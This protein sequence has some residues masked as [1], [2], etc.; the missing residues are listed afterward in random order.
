VA[1][2]KVDDNAPHHKKM[3]A[4]GDAACWLWVCGLAY[5]QRH[6]TDGVITPE[7]VPFL[8]CKGWKA[9]VP[10]LV[11]SG[12]W[13]V[14]GSGYRVH[15]FLH[16]NDSAEVRRQKIR[17]VN[18][19][20]TRF[21][22]AKKREGNAVGNS[23]PTPQP[24]PQPTPQPES[25]EHASPPTFEP[26]LPKGAPGSSLQW[27]RLHGTHVGGFC[28]W[29]CLPQEDFTRFASRLGSDSAAMA[30]A[31]AVRAS[32]VVATGKPWTFW[33]E[34]FDAAHGAAQ[35]AGGFSAAD[36]AAH[37]PGGAIDKKLGIK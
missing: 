29:M 28:D 37:M 20:V 3:L 15:D 9:A 32:G 2:L 23:T 4:A 17:D 10:K 18:E 22:E 14:D 24:L 5:C 35:K 19:R 12:L 34:Q 27:H 13:A 30:W 26:R 25:G 36:W 8:G 6:M 7:A 33:N 21:R 1:W 16:W 31:Q 11:A